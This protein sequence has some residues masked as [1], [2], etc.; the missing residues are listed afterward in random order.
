MG[1]T[2]SMATY[3]SSGGGLT[4]LGTYVNAEFGVRPAIKVRLSESFLSSVKLENS[5]STRNWPALGAMM[6]IHYRNPKLLAQFVILFRCVFELTFSSLAFLPPWCYTLSADWEIT[7][8]YRAREFD[9]K[10]KTICKNRTKIRLDFGA[11]AQL[12]GRGTRTYAPET[13]LSARLIA[14]WNSRF[15]LMKMSEFLF[16]MG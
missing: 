9:N 16:V 1:Y 6:L 14:H 2:N 5:S 15:S 7:S 12:V 10:G 3:V 13:G 8:W 11:L 4:R